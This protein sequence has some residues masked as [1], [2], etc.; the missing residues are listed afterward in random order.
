MRGVLP[1]E[2]ADD[3]ARAE[4]DQQEDGPYRAKDEDEEPTCLTR[5]SLGRDGRC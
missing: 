1:A 5:L 2:Y 3:Q 4:A